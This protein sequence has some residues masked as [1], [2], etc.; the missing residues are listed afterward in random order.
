LRITQGISLR[1]QEPS[2]EFDNEVPFL[3]RHY[4][5]GWILYNFIPNII[6]ENNLKLSEFL[7]LLRAGEM[8]E[9]FPVL[10]VLHADLD[11]VKPVQDVQLGKGHGRVVVHLRLKIH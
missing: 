2:F 8:I 7:Y 6:D 10:D 4:Y 11:L 5:K 3:Y 1:N 9:R